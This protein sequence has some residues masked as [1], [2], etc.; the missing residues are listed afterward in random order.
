MSD[1]TL[2]NIEVVCLVMDTARRSSK[3]TVSI[4]ENQRLIVNLP[5]G[6]KLTIDYSGGDILKDQVWIGRINAAGQY[7]RASLGKSP[8]NF[9]TQIRLAGQNAV[10][11]ERRDQA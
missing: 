11:I 8:Y 10:S 3:K 2:N 5:N 7:D 6:E 1:S 9:E 4:V